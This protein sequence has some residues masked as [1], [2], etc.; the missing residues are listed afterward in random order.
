MAGKARPSILG[1]MNEQIIYVEQ[2]KRRYTNPSSA[3]F[4]NSGESTD[5]AARY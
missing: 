1:G 3:S 2:C 5:A 4:K